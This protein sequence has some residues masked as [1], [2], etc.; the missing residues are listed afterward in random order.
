MLRKGDLV[1]YSDECIGIVMEDENPPWRR[2]WVYWFELDVTMMMR[3]RLLK[4]LSGKGQ[5]DA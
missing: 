4:V 5:K 2:V 1:N 3:S